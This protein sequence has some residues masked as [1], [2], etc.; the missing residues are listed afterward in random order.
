MITPN[1]IDECFKTGYISAKQRDL[2]QHQISCIINPGLRKPA[3]PGC[4]D[5]STYDG[6][7]NWS[8]SRISWVIKEVLLYE[9]YALERTNNI[10]QAVFNIRAYFTEGEISQKVMDAAIEWMEFIYAGEAEDYRTIAAE[11][12]YGDDDTR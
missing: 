3:E 2:M 4:F 12:G 11:Y 1:T 7:K 5:L 10:N 9:A 6:L 8:S